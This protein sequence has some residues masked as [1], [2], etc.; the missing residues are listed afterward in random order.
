MDR[1]NYL[2]MLQ[3]FVEQV[4][5]ASEEVLR[6]LLPPPIPKEEK[7]FWISLLPH[8]AQETFFSFP[9]ET[10][11]SNCPPHFLQTNS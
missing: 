7:V 9:I 10:R 5:Q 3:V 11:V 2:H 1:A 8:A 6:W 4:V